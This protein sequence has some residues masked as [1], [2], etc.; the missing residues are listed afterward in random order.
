MKTLTKMGVALAILIA[1]SSYLINECIGV[2]VGI[3]LL[4][5]TIVAP[6]IKK[7]VARHDHDLITGWYAIILFASLFYDF[8]LLFFVY[9]ETA[10]ADVWRLW[11]WFVGLLIIA[12]RV[13]RVIFPEAEHAEQK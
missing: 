13:M 4:A 3:L 8:C 10:P 11:F 5:A 9:S 7:R 6:I 2:V 1:G 12:I